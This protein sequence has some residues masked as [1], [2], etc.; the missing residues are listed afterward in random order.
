MKIRRNRWMSATVV[1]ALAC[2]L[3]VVQAA[4]PERSWTVYGGNPEMTLYSPL[5]QINRSNVTKL[6]VAWT[7]DAEEGGGYPETQPLMVKGVLYG[8]TPRHKIIA[9]DAVTGK[10]IWKFDSGVEARGPNRGVTYWESGNERILFASVKSFVYALDPGTGKAIP[11]FGKNGRI[12]LREGLGREPEEQT[13]N[14][15]SPGVIYKDLL[16]VGGQTPENLP[17]PPGDIRAFEVRTG[18]LRWTFHTIP[19][20][21]E[22]GYE[23]WPKDAWKYSGAATAWTGMALDEKRGIVFAPTGNPAS[24]MYGADRTGDNLF[25]CTLLALDANTG[26]RLW[27]FQ[28]VKHDIW[29]R[30]LP[31]PPTLV[32]VTHQG[33]KI[34]AVALTSKLGYLYLFDRVTGKSLFPLEEKSYPPSDVPGEVA[35]PT[36]VLPTKPAPY[37]RTHLTEDMLSRRTPEVYQ[38]ALE[39]FRKFRSDGLFTP[40][41]VDRQTIMMPMMDGGAEWGGSAFDPATSIIY[42]NSNDVAF[43]PNLVENTIARSVRQIYLNSCA[44]CHGDSRQGS[45]DFPALTRLQEEKVTQ[46]AVIALVRK[47]SGRMPSFPNLTDQQV[48]ALAQYVLSGENIELQTAASSAGTPKYRFGGGRPFVDSEGYPAIAPPWGTLNA[49]NLN[50]GDYVWRIP[51]GEYPELAAK[52]MKNTG[53]TNYGGP[54]LTAGGILFIG[55]TNFDNKFRAFD[56]RD[57][58]LLWETTLPFGGNA[59][60]ITYEIGGKQYVAIY[61]GGGGKFG[62][63]DGKGGGVYVAFALP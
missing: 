34:D 41:S 1:G 8:I 6:K 40:L 23:T 60:P 42:F 52:G 13:M 58:K 48:Q 26:K 35:S 10:P 46:Q 17:A 28:T 43:A 32:T 7:F 56:K 16:I 51:F 50:T 3:A 20:P 30:D 54:L 45:Q 24:S 59:T 29:D 55:A 14:L 5:K 25:S 44:G 49:I 19:H 57:G 47:G 37:A 63:R 36:Q 15:T 12:D 9:L 33:K 38:R 62:R 31:A 4:P 18:K 2:V 22:F 27:H 39:Q 53:T 61:A 11:A 21:G